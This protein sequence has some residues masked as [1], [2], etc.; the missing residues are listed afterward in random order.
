MYS[1]IS[2]KYSL[3]KLEKEPFSFVS[4]PV[5]DEYGRQIGRI[6]SFVVSPNG[7]VNGVFIKHENDK[8]HRYSTNQFK[9]KGD[10]VTVF[11]SVKAKAEALYKETPL[12]LRRDQAL[13]RLLEKEKISQETFNKLHKNFETALNRMKVDAQTTLENIDKRVAR[14]NQQIKELRLAMVYL[15]LERAIG[16]IDEKPCQT[17]MKEMKETLNKVNAEKVDLEA[18]RNKLSNMLGEEATAGVEAETEKETVPALPAL[19]EPPIEV[20]IKS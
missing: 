1:V 3:E 7:R 18:T 13:S 9:T 8:F 10:D 5:T 6:A 20:R 16:K 4:R 2:W 12:I 15:M 17:A 11:S 19:P 14:C